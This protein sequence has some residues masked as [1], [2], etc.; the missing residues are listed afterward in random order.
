MGPAV[1]A[2]KRARGEKREPSE[3]DAIPVTE[4]LFGAID[5]VATAAFLSEDGTRVIACLR[6]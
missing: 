5:E 3:A 4:K 2:G 6:R 1:G